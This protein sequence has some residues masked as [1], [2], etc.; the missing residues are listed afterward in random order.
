VPR[1]TQRNITNAVIPGGDLELLSAAVH[2]VAGARLEWRTDAAVRAELAHLVGAADRLRILTPVMH[3]EMVSEIRWTSSEVEASRDGIDIETLGLS[4]SDRAGLELC[5]DWSSLQLLSEMGLGRNLEKMSAKHVNS[6]PAI[7]LIT[8]PGTGAAQHFHAGR[9]VQR[10]WLMAAKIGIAVHPM[11][12]LPYFFARLLRGGGQGF[13]QWA[14]TELR[15]L[16]SRFE[17]CFQPIPGAAE[18][19]LFR[20]GVAGGI[21][22]GSLR[23]PV[24]EVLQFR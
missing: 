9:A 17:L 7:G 12:A 24:E 16:R 18:V 2:S 3:H 11:T 1:H 5:R 4:A 15:T 19:F 13:P 21:V 10:M 8:I 23:R 6:A 22:K 20:I 14:V